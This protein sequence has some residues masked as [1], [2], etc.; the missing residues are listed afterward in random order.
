MKKILALF[1]LLLTF[2]YCGT[3]AAKELNVIVSIPPLHSLVSSLMEGAGE[4]ILL[5]DGDMDQTT[6]LDPFQKSQVI[7]ADMMVW[8]GPGLESPLEQT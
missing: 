2:V 6:V 1:T 7:T 5:F 8:V 4:P 3:V